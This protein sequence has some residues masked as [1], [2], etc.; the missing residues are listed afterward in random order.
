MRLPIPP[1]RQGRRDFSC[2]PLQCQRKSQEKPRSDDVIAPSGRRRRARLRR[3]ILEALNARAR[4]AHARRA[5]RSACDDRRR[6]RRAFE[7]ALA[8][9]E[10]AGE[11]MQN[12]AGACSSPSASRW[13]PGASKAIPTATASSCPTTAAPSVFLPP[14][15]MRQLMHGDRA[16]VRVDG[17]RPARPAARRGGRGA[18][19]RATAASSGGCTRSTACCSSCPRTGASRTTSWCRR[20]RPAA[21]SPGRW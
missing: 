2:R 21:R 17:P 1:P 18:R 4:A 3:E 12:R 15:E 13:S 10:R 5:G 11:V 9:L 16:A 7:R 6:A 20:P 19:A 8:A 14:A